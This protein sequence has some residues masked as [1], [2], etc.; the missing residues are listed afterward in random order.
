M[1]ETAGE[2]R[3][4]STDNTGFE[5]IMKDMEK[6]V[7][8]MSEFM[9]SNQKEISYSESLNTTNGREQTIEDKKKYE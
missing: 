2:D 1:E 6:R 5:E 9:H 4:I 3:R 8:H 7:A